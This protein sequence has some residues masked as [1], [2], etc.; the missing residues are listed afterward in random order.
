MAGLSCFYPWLIWSGGRSCPTDLVRA[1]TK[2]YRK[3]RTNLFA[4]SCS[5]R[6]GYHYWGWNSC[7][8]H[9]RIRA[10][11]ETGR[12]T[13]GSLPSGGCNL[14]R[15]DALGVGCSSPA[16]PPAVQPASSR[17][18]LCFPQKK[19]LPFQAS[20]VTSVGN[21]HAVQQQSKR[22]KVRGNECNAALLRLEALARLISCRVTPCYLASASRTAG[23]G[24][25]GAHH[26][27]FVTVNDP[28]LRALWGLWGSGR[29]LQWPPGL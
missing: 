1:T 22:W 19:H 3:Q 8:Y 29:R 9:L 4:V 27:R 23:R 10:P 11:S 15:T 16:S 6:D 18:R 12:A 13:A 17:R 7:Q 26:S 20:P 24:R 14:D 2:Q 21:R 28:A 5:T 25:S